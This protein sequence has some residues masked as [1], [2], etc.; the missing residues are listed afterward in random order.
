MPKMDGLA[1]LVKLRALPRG[2]EL[3]VIVIT[4]DALSSDETRYLAAGMDAYVPKPVDKT[5]LIKTCVE[6]LKDG[7]SFHEADVQSA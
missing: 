3:P 1:T 4:A 2:Q 5:R 7:R 6:R